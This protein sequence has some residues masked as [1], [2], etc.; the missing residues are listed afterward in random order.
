MLQNVSQYLL[1]KLAVT[2]SV[3][4]IRFST[5]IFRKYFL[6][7]IILYIYHKRIDNYFHVKPPHFVSD[8]W[9]CLTVCCEDGEVEYSSQQNN[10]LYFLMFIRSFISWAQSNTTNHTYS[11]P[12][13]SILL[14][15]LPSYRHYSTPSCQ[16]LLILSSVRTVLSCLWTPVNRAFLLFPFPFS[17]IASQVN[18]ILP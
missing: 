7:C 1:Y 14:H 15:C 6:S 16:Q 18:N 11:C 3:H 13:V 9:C 8:E 5:I 12:H 17:T 2:T 4:F 10:L